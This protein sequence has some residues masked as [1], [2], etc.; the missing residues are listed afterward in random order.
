MIRIKSQTCAE[1]SRSINTNKNVQTLFAPYK[2]TPG[3][4][5]VEEQKIMADK[6]IA[7]IKDN[8]L[9]K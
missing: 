1:Q 7:F 2:N 6:L 8:K 4:P 5:R 9:W 3:H